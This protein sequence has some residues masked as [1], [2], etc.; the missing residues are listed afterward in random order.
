MD[1]LKTFFPLSFKYV[2]SVANLVI[3]VIIY[4]IVGA[5]AGALIGFVGGL[6]IPLVGILAK[7]VGT[8]MEIYC[9]GG[10]VIMFLRHFN[11]LKD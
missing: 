3:G 10:I 4:V 11:V 7:I 9:T 8:V 5:I 6:E 1:A 2:G